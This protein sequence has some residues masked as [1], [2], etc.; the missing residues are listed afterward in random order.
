MD[1]TPMGTRLRLRRVPHPLRLVSACRSN[2]VQPARHSANLT[3]RRSNDGHL[4]AG[5]PSTKPSR[6]ENER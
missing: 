5:M 1:E 4:V 2:S 3:H 6:Q